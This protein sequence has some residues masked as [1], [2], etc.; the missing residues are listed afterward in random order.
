MAQPG[1]WTFT[2]H[3][4]VAPLLLALIVGLG[5]FCRRAL[6]T[7]RSIDQ[8]VLPHFTPRDGNADATLPGRVAR[9]ESA[10]TALDG[11]LRVHMAD[12]AR[13]RGTDVSE[14]KGAVTRIHDRID[15]LTDDRE[16]AR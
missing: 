12:E 8:H 4:V 5:A 6:R 3:P 16:A 11:D 13:Q 7:L 1:W 9:V 14:L 10:V 2:A 15:A